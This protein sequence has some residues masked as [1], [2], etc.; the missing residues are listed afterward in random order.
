M[1]GEGIV[2]IGKVYTEEGDYKAEARK[3]ITDLY[4]YNLGPVLFKPTLAADKQFRTT[5]EGGTFVF[6]WTQ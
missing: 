5:E 1:W 3:H 2:R 6:C 4:G